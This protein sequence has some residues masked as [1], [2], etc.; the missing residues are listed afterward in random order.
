[1]C[2][3]EAAGEPPFM[4]F[5]PLRTYKRLDA[6]PLT[7]GE[8]VELTFDLFATSV[9]LKKGHRIRIAI[10]GADRDSFARYP[11]D[12]QKVPTVQIERN[13]KYPSKIELPIKVL[14]ADDVSE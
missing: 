8:I 12:N 6:S 13:K 10:A 9:V 5:G 4:Y 11:L 1:M 2:R 3:K 7:R 14:Q